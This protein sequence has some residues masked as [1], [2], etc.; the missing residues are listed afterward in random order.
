MR[1][2]KPAKGNLREA[3]IEA[4]VIRADGTTENLGVVSRWHKNPLVRLK[5]RTADL[6]RMKR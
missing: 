4:V 6:L 3:S 5:W 1:K 2:L